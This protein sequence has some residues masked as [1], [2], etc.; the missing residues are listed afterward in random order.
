MRQHQEPSG[1]SYEIHPAQTH[2]GRSKGAAG[3]SFVSAARQRRFNSGRSVREG[4]GPGRGSG[5]IGRKRGESLRSAPGS[6]KIEHVSV[7]KKPLNILQVCDHLGWEGSRMHGVKR[8]FSW[9]IPRFDPERFKVSLVSLRR[10]D[11][12][13]ETLEAQGI[14][15]TYLNRGKFDPLTPF[16]LLRVVDERRSDVLHVH[17]YGA[18]T[19]GR[20]AAARRRLPTVLHEHANLTDTPWFQKVADRMLEPATD[21]ALAVSKSTADFVIRAR[22]IP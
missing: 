16:D 19:F 12:S 11:L 1:F 9:M 2:K 17:G 3:A 7:T 21:I 8:L 15:I 14:D 4:W 10:K 13:E 20:L 5:E 18:T 6:V 22:L